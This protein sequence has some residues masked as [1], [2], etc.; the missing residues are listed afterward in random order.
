MKIAL[1]I[2]GLSLLKRPFGKLSNR[3]KRLNRK[4]FIYILFGIVLAMVF[5]TGAALKLTSTPQ[6][7]SSCHE[8]KP[9]YTTW[10]QTSHSKIACVQCHIEPG[11]VNL[12]KHKL[13]SMTQLYEHLTGKVP[14][15]ITM[16]ET[17][18][19]DVCEQCHSTMRQVTASGDIIIPHDKHLKQ[20]I[21]C[22]ACHAGVVHGFATERGLTPKN[23]YE[24]WTEEKAQ[25]VTSFDDTKS[26]MEACLDCHDQVNAGKKPWLEKEGVA[27]T[28]KERVEESRAIKA[29]A[30]GE[31]P[32]ENATATSSKPSENA[33][34]HPPTIQ[35][36]ACHSTM[37]TPNS[38][39][40]ATWGTTHGLEA[41]KD[42][43]VCAEC[44]S[45][46][47]E[48]ALLK[49]N[50]DVKDYVRGN[51]FCMNC[52]EKRPAGHLE[53]KKD[54]LPVHPAFIKDKNN[55]GCLVCHDIEKPK[56]TPAE[57]G[58]PANGVPATQ[59]YCNLCHWFSN[60][61]IE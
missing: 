26:T 8:M 5:A 37:K 48:R 17:I 38:H 45:R 6:F 41:R 32:L 22:I 44:H 4:Q 3:L 25:K 57:N 27:K 47:K 14:N 36:Q 2:K 9:E 16:S 34:M 43:R 29:M 60:N 35:C 46:Q 51:A 10:Q 56:T 20:G 21:S 7:C 28:E 52:H 55:P 42:V 61:K 59:V 40:E 24:T 12:V 31:K 58:N 18:K 1:N 54:W 49:V 11:A 50:T 39:S 30:N 33:T 19:N 53:S 13:N 15:P 23:D